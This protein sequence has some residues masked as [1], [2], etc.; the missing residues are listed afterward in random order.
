MSWYKSG[1]VSLTNGSTA[2]VGTGTSWIAGAA[3]GEGFIGPDGKTYEIAN[4]GS[5]TSITLG[6]AYQ[7]ATASGQSYQIIPSQSYIRDLASQA[8]T[9]IS[10]YGTVLENA[11]TGKF[12]DGSV[13]QPGI[14]FTSDENTG[15]RRT[16][17]D[18]MALVVNGSDK[19]TISPTGVTGITKTD[20]GLANVDNTSD[21]TKNAATATLTNKTIN[22]ASNTL[23][24]TSAQLAAAV[25]DE[26]GSGSL[27]FSA[28]A[29]LTGTPT[30]PTATAGTN[31]TQLATTAFVGTAITNERTA[32]ATLA[33]KTLTSPVITTPTLSTEAIAVT[34]NNFPTIRPSLNLD[35]ANSQSV[36]PRITFTRASTATRTNAKGLIESVA[37]GVPRIDY[38]PITLA[39][40]G[41]LVEESRTNLLT[42]SEQFDNAAWTK[43]RATVTAN[44]VVSPDGTVDADKLVEDTTASN[45]HEAYVARSGSNETTTFSV[46]LKSAE[47]TKVKI[48]M[49][50]FATASCGAIFDLSAGS[51]INDATNADYT[52]ISS[53]IQSVGNGWFRCCITATKGSV[54]TTNNA[55]IGLINGS[56]QTY[57][58]DGTSGIYIWGAQL[59]VG[60]FPT[61]YIPS[62]VTHTGR[63]ST[64]TFIGSNGLIQTAASGVARYSYN[65]LNLSAAPAL[66]LEET[67]T[68]LLTYSSELDN[69]VWGKQSGAT[70]TANTATAPDGTLTAD[71]LTGNGSGSYID[72]TALSLTNGQKYAASFYAKAGTVSTVAAVFYGANFN[73]G[74]ANINPQFD[75]ASGVVVSAGGAENAQIQSVGNGWYRCSFVVTLTAATGPYINQ[76]IRTPAAA[77]TLFV[78]GAQIEAGSYPTSYIP[79]VASQ[80]TRAAD[81]STS[82]TT[83]RAADVAVMTGANFSSWWNATEGSFAAE[84]SS[85]SPATTGYDRVFSVDDGTNNNIIAL[86]KH[87]GAGN[88]YSTVNV[89]GSNQ[90]TL[91]TVSMAANTAVRTAVAYKANDFAQSHN[92]ATVVTDTSGSI[93]VVT[94][95]GFTDQLSSVTGSHCIRS[96]RYYPKRLSNAQLQ[97]I[98]TP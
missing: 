28:T 63:S 79:T 75:L 16:G 94:K 31:T 69:P 8:A 17:A 13:S 67:R 6:T 49:S 70:I 24:A 34:T 4:I 64:A 45:T 7:G 1:T 86:L 48:E 9:L 35:F 73:A 42:Y 60:S 91:Y 76:L 84:Y 50:N 46:Y 68:N 26:T 51:S 95:F 32:T 92:G 97:T 29:A 54:N 96:L 62:A 20:V 22:L 82:A 88:Y 61:T 25:T 66:L 38:D 11:G 39:C 14:R 3:V 37:S 87:N 59:E 80:V 18:T 15:I 57:T 44:A 90:M 85:A 21:A 77:G 98:T 2:V 56:V 78:W 47:R 36:D 33:N 71:T 72:H 89:G 27:V 19:V 5:N 12:G 83:T 74:G 81:T 43:A 30:A 23:V 40:K 93:P 65:P 52:S 10:D 53:S 41:L 58:G 55:Y